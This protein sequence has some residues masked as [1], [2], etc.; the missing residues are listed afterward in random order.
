GARPTPRGPGYP[1]AV[2]GRQRVGSRPGASAA[3]SWW[4][5]RATA[6]TVTAGFT[7]EE[8]LK[9][10]KEDPRAPG[11]LFDRVGSLLDDLL[12]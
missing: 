10:P 2:Q 1:G 12:K 4:T 6:G 9:P 5:A 7:K 11:G 3:A 8:I